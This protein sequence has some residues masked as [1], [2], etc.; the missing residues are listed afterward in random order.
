VSRGRERKRAERKRRGKEERK[1]GRSSFLLGEEKGT[2]LFSVDTEE[3]RGR[4]M[5]CRER[6]RGRSSFLLTPKRGRGR[7]IPCRESP[8]PLREDMSTTR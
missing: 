4:F 7:F 8:A 5:P 3:G 2:Q 1:R 6:K